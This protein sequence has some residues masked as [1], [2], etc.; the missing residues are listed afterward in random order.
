[1]VDRI[2]HLRLRLSRHDADVLKKL[3][4]EHMRL[5]LL[6]TNPGLTDRAIRRFFRHLGVDWLGAM[7]I[8]WADG[9]A[10]G[11][12]TRHLERAFTRMIDL[13]RAD[14]AKPTVERLVNGHDLIALGMEPGPVFKVILQELLDLQLEGQVKDKAQALEAA[15]K[16]A[17]R[18]AQDQGPA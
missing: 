1:M 2:A 12:K 9:Y 5:H 13:Y 7:I 18:L 17:G 16:I 6:A 10:T 8:A 14:A 3:V 11:G 4:K 15:Q